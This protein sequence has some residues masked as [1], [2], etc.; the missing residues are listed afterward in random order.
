M[1]DTEVPAL[2]CHARFL[3]VPP[4]LLFVCNAPEPRAQGQLH[5]LHGVA[6]LSPVEG[7]ELGIGEIT[8]SVTQPLTQLAH[9]V[10]YRCLHLSPRANSRLKSQ[11]QKGRRPAGAT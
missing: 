3:A 11:F 9:I 7:C 5:F 6:R 10:I 1:D 8:P 4:S 2:P